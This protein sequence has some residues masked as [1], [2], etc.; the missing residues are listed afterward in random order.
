MIKNTTGLDIRPAGRL[1]DEA[2]RFSSTVNIIKGNGTYS[3]KS[4]LSV[5]GACVRSGEEIV[6]EC[7]GEDENEALE[8]LVELIDNGL[9]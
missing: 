6:L 3:A 5:L 4:M 9:E 8:F 7:E 2:V 1:C